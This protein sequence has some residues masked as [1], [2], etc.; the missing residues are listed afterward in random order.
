MILFYCCY[1][2]ERY[3]FDRLLYVV[4]SSQSDHFKQLVLSCRKLN[5][6]ESRDPYQSPDD[7][8]VAFGRVRGMSTRKGNVVFLTDILDEAQ[9]RMKAVMLEK[10][11]ECL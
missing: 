8:H 10:E 2:K 5:I 3:D 9:S 6:I 4:D 1:R 7:Y 11:S